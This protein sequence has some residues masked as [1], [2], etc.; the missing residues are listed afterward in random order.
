M[1]D[2]NRIEPFM[3]EIASTWK[4]KFLD[5]RF[6]Q[7]MSNFFCAFGDLFYYE[8]EELLEAFRA[9]ASGKE[10]KECA[11]RTACI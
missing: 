10:I 4:E 11:A 3:N 5:W 6:G 7:M 2:I 8:E 9:F 1:R